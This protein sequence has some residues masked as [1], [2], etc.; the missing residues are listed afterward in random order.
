V[1]ED[2]TDA[3]ELTVAMLVDLGYE[4]VT[5]AE[6]GAAAAVLDDGAGVDLLLADVILPGGKSGPGFAEEAK[7]RRSGIKVLFMSG[8]LTETLLRHGKLDDDVALLG[9]PFSKGALARKLREA[10][11][12]G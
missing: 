8:Y 1:L 11:D 5:A 3:R 10:L 6:A 2:A 4:V 12:R 7:R 9:K